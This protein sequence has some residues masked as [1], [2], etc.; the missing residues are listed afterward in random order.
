MDR[1]DGEAGQY[2]QQVVEDMDGNRKLAV[3]GIKIPAFGSVML[4]M[5]EG[6]QQ[7]GSVF[8]LSGVKEEILERLL[9]MKRDIWNPLW[10]SAT[11]AS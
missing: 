10:T 7:S 9:L 11:D 4:T 2:R 5:E 8:T 6:A 3:M 1:V